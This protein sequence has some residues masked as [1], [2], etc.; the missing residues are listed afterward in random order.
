MEAKLFDPSGYVCRISHME[1]EAKAGAFPDAKVYRHKGNITRIDLPVF[2][3]IRGNHSGPTLFPRTVR[4]MATWTF[5]PRIKFQ[6][7]TA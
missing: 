7:E 4:E 5:L 1:A 2:C 6:R 3:K